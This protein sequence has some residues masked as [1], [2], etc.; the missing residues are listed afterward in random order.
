MRILRKTGYFFKNKKKEEEKLN[1]E[2]AFKEGE[3]Y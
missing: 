3:F 2:E 1:S